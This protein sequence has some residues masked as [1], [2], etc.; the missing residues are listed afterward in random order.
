[1]YRDTTKKQLYAAVQAINT[2][3]EALNNLANATDLVEF[4]LEFVDF[5]EDGAE[6]GDFGVGHLHGVAR[7]VV[8]HLCCCLSLLRELRENQSVSI[9]FVIY[10]CIAVGVG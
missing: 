1:M 10:V 7:A 4:D 3:L 8:L 5:A 2:G 9:L 6:A